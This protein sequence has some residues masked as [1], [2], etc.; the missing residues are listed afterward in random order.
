M[1]RVILFLLGFALTV[2][3]L[4][5]CIQTPDEKVQHLP[6]P[7]WLLLIVIAP[8]AGPVAWLLIGRRRRVGRTGPPQ[9]RGPIGPDDDPDFL[10]GL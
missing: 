3:A 5:D 10:R 8:L 9:R 2:Y 7:L 1:P 4:T 6:K